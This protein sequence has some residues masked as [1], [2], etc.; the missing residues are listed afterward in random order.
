M[1]ILLAQN[2]TY[3]PTNGGANKGNKLLLEALAERGHA[4]RMI[5]LSTSVQ[6]YATRDRFLDELRTR[7]IGPVVSEQEVDVFEHAGVQIHAAANTRLLCR[8]LAAQA[9]AFRPDWTLVSSEDTGQVV[10]A[11]ALNAC[12]DRTIYLA[13]TTWN[14]PFGPASFRP[15]TEGTRLLQQAAGMITVNRHLRDYIRRWAD[16]DAVHIPLSAMTLGKGP[17]PHFGRCDRGCVTMVNPCAIK[18]IS[19]FLALARALPA[20][21]FAA[22]PSWG[23]TAADLAQLRE[24]PNVTILDPADDIDAILSR[25]RVLLVPSLWDE[26]FARIVAEAMLR[27]IPVLASDVGGLPES[28]L[29]VDYVLPVRP[30]THYQDRLD[31]KMKPIP[32]VPE[33]DIEPWRGASKGCSPIQVDTRLCRGPRGMR[34]SPPIPRRRSP[35]ER[36]NPIWKA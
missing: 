19:I 8:Q 9:D 14:L 21:A 15:A 31:D 13:R 29:G 5:A 2:M 18:G 24:S 10:L 7:G 16:L 26:A 25:T 11:G 3:L 35:S 30:I 33:Q 4:C 20:V 27:A 6:G 28:K 34:R 23:T 32:A 12:P 1:R 36:W 17:F 22:V